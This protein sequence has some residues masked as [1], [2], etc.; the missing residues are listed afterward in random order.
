MYSF[1]A[2]VLS[3][4]QIHSR[5]ILST[6]AK[7]FYTLKVGTLPTPQCSRKHPPPH[8]YKVVENSAYV[9]WG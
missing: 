1:P 9:V 8:I 3:T 6:L 4:N 2:L 7:R 5:F